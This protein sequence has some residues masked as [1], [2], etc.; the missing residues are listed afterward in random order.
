[1]QPTYDTAVRDQV[2]QHMSPIDQPLMLL[3]LLGL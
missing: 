2:R 1:M 3:E